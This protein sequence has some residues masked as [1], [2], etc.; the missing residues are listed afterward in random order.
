MLFNLLKSL[1]LIV[2]SAYF[3]LSNNSNAIFNLAH[4]DAAKPACNI[5]EGVMN[6]H[7]DLMFFLVMIFCFVMTFL[8]LIV[9]LNENGKFKILVS[10][11]IPGKLYYFVP[12]FKYPPITHHTVL[13][14][15]W[16]VTPSLIL[17]ILIVPTFS[18]IYT[19]DDVFDGQMTVKV[20][21]HQ[22]YWSYEYGDLTENLDEHFTDENTS[23][24][25]DSYMQAEDDLVSGTLRLLE[26]D[27]RLILPTG[28]HIHVLITSTDVIHSWAIPS[29]GVKLDACPGRLNQLGLYITRPGVYYGQCSEIC[30][31][32]HAFMPICI[33]TV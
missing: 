15:I 20:I 24:S 4:T 30:G 16:T 31:I 6:L 26:V 25:F 13:E 21:G 7:D 1:L 32:N 19:L 10:K 33:E 27:N 18:L 5:M 11:Q 28:V 23:Y 22:W 2:M 17:L 8:T 14:F 29:L 9:T 3:V 12:N